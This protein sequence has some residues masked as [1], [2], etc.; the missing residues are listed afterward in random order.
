LRECDSHLRP[1]VAGWQTDFLIFFAIR[2][3]MWSAALHPEFG[4]RHASIKQV[5]RKLRSGEFRLYSQKKHPETG[6]RRNVGT[7]DS[8]ETSSLR[9]S[10]QAR[11]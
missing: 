5:I 10:G 9:I 2:S 4:T 7:F 3:G 8:R 11:K 6:K 1:S